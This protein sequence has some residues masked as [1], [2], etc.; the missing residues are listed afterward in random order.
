MEYES[1]EMGVFYYS[2]F[3]KFYLEGYLLQQM[4]IFIE[5]YKG[6]SFSYSEVKKLH[7]YL[8][9]IF[10]ADFSEAFRRFEEKTVN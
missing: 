8:V 6:G 7:E 9:N 3:T 10:T 4:A 1:D 2:A 5:L